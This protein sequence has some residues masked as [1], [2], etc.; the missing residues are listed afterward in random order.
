MR[1]MGEDRLVQQIFP[2]TGEF[3][4][5]CDMAGN[6]PRAPAGAAHHDAV[7]DFGSARGAKR[8][9]IEIDM[10]Q[11]LH[12]AEAAHGIEAEC[13]AFHHPAVAKMQPDG[14]R[15][16]NQIADRQHQPV[17]DHHAIAGALGTQRIGAE[18]VGRDDRVQADHRRKHP[19]EIEA[20][21]AGAG[22]IRRRHF[23]FSQRGHGESPGQS[24]RR[25]CADLGG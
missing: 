25:R 12:Q 11:R 9:R 23:P 6:R 1:G 14:F 17:V 21:V 19:I 13:V 3:L 2:V 20:V 18:G 22:L 7:A 4:L 16:G 24:A 8:Q 10:A 15:L 5:C